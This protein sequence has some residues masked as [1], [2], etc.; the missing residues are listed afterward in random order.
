MRFLTLI[1]CAAVPLAFSVDPAFDDGQQADI[2]RAASAWNARTID[3]ITFEAGEWR[4]E[5]RAPAPLGGRQ[6]LG[7]CWNSKRLIQ[8]HPEAGVYAVA[9]HEFGHA[10]GLGHVVGGVMD[11]HASHTEFTAGDMAE[12]RRA[13]ACKE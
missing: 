5:Q 6:P 13:G 3:R 10:H 2:A 9:L 4:I 8:I 1:A 11:P 7:Y 12:C